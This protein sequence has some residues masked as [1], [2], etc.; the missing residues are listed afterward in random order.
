MVTLTT[1]DL[2]GPRRRHDWFRDELGQ[3]LAEQ[4]VRWRWRTGDDVWVIGTIA[5]RH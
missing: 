1:D 5:L 3:W 4:G 2:D